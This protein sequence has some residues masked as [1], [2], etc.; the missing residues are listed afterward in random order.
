MWLQLL[1]LLAVQLAVR[2]ESSEH[3]LSVDVYNPSVGALNQ[4]RPGVAG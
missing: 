3:W 1:A 2:T 4:D